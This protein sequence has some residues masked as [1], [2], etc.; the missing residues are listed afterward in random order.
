MK[1]ICVEVCFVLLLG[2]PLAAES[3]GPRTNIVLILADDLGYGDV[4]AYN[5]A[6]Q[7]IMAANGV[8]IND[9][10]TFV[11]PQMTKLQREVNVHFTPDGSKALAEQVATAIKAAL[12]IE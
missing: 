1:K 5:A 11:L 3:L 4:Q 8:S 6:A 2:L 10:Y 9:L 7:K 12:S